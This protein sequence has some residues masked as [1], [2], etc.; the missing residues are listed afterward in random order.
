M[1]Y[2]QFRKKHEERMNGLREAMD[3]LNKSLENRIE[4]SKEDTDKLDRL[5]EDLQKLLD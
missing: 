1:N 3:S 2:E 5:M 4:I